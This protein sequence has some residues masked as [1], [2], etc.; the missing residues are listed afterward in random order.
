MYRTQ[1]DY[2][3]L[4]R[5]QFNY[6]VIH[7]RHFASYL[8]LADM[9]AAVKFSSSSDCSVLQA[10]QFLDVNVFHILPGGTGLSHN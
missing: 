4:Y 3:C 2:F 5:T 1:V 10:L 8:E 9:H 6:V 7:V